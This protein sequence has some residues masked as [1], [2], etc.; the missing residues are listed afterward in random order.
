MSLLTVS[1]GGIFY[2]FGDLSVNFGVI[3]SSLPMTD[4]AFESSSL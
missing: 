1:A 2:R 3:I 4:N